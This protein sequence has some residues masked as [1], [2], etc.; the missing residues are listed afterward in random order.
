MKSA[1][2]ITFDCRLSASLAIAVAVLAALAIVAIASCGLAAWVKWTLA[3]AV[4]AHAAGV[5]LRMSRLP[6]GRCS[7]AA[8]HWRVRGRDGQ[9]HAAVLLRAAV[10]G[11]L[12]VLVLL[13]GPLRRVTV[14][15]LPDNCDADTRRR[16]RVE[17]SRG[18]SEAA[19][20]ARS[21]G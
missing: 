19:A 7:L 4:V 1:A 18:S 8:G 11:P 21:P 3:V 14:V 9:D 15:L 2:A 16:L 20:R 10:R 13:A 6:V 5:L 17:L 12:I